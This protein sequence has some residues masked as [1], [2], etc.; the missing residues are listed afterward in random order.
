MAWSGSIG[1]TDAWTRRFHPAPQSD[2]RLV[3]FPHAGG[4]ASFFF[5][6]S[7][8]LSP[9]IDVLV[10]QYPG[11]QDRRLEKGVDNIPELADLCA[12]A[13]R[14]WNDRPLALFGHSMGATL[15]FEVARRLERTAGQQPAYLFVSGRRA[16]HL[17]RDE[18]VHLR[19]DAGLVA[20]MKT[21]SDTDAELLDDEEVLQM[22]LPALR[23][24]Y[25]AIETYVYQPRPKLNCPIHALVGDSDPRVTVEEAQGWAKHTS[26]IFDL[27]VFSGGH[28]YLSERAPEVIETISRC[29]GFAPCQGADTIT[30][31]RESHRPDGV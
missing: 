10:V 11:R 24:D 6:I 4:S 29:L 8:V 28:F 23:S 16:P 17:S 12:A 31:G 7:R 21:L 1:G 18:Q 14:R 30:A 19:D 15:A 26:G 13:L 5:P 9:A 25:K 2:I 20:E 3:C 22:I 27:R